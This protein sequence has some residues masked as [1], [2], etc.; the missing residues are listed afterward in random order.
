[1]V[2]S[3][4]GQQ[5]PQGGKFCAFCGRTAES[6]DTPCVSL[7]DM[8]ETMPSASSDGSIRCQTKVNM[9]RLLRVSL[10]VVLVLSLLLVSLHV[11]RLFFYKR[12]DFACT[13]TS[14]KAFMKVVCHR[15]DAEKTEL[16]YVE[17]YKN[18]YRACVSV[19]LEGREAQKVYVIFFGDEK[20]EKVTEISCSFE[21][22]GKSTRNGVDYKVAEALVKVM[23]PLFSDVSPVKRLLI[24]FDYWPDDCTSEYAQS[25]IGEW[26]NKFS[27]HVD[28]KYRITSL[29]FAG[30]GHVQWSLCKK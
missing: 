12:M 23:R 19:T 18:Y 4:C 2:C 30:Y 22:K 25:Y 17:G 27:D 7:H 8:A 9:K 24:N 3:N 11:G 5:I 16:L 1:M 21:L 29:D 10:I 6:I 26:E 20:S 15:V 14:I 28:E 13:E